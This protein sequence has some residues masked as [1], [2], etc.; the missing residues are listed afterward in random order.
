MTGRTENCE[1]RL[2]ARQQGHW[3]QSLVALGGVMAENKLRRAWGTEGRGDGVNVLAD[4]EKQGKP[5]GREME[6]EGLGP[7]S[8]GPCKVF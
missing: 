4:K 6:S 1:Q 2:S 7:V 8:K 3:A 5:H